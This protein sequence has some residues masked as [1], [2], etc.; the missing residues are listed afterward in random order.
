[1]SA[2]DCSITCC[3]VTCVAERL[4]HLSPVLGHDEAVRQHRVVG[5]AAAR[6]AAF[7]QRGMEPAAM[8]VG[9]FEIED[10]RPFQVRPLLQHEGMRGA[11]IEPDVEDVVDLL[12]FGRVVGIAEEALLARP[13][14]TRRRRPPRERP[15]TMRAFTASSFSTSPVSRLTKTAIGTPQA[16]WRDTTQSGRFSIM[17][18][19]RFCPAAGTK[20]VS[21]IAFSAR[22]RS[23]SPAPVDVAVHVDEPLR[24]VAEDHR[25][26]RAPGMR[27]L[28]LQPAARDQHAGLRQRLDHGRRWRRPSRPSSV[29]TC[30][31]S[32]PGASRG[33]RAV[34]IDR[35][36]DR[37]VD[38]ALLQLAAMLHPDVEVLAAVAGRGVD[39]AGAGLLGHVL[40]GQQRHVEADSRRARRCRS[41]CAATSV[42]NSL[43]GTSASRSNVSTRACFIT[44]AASASAST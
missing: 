39:E 7:Q 13:R 29:M 38:A 20:R 30:R 35:V 34:G 9:A 37:R 16:R 31:P 23:V 22:A 17:P 26:L 11:G 42:S 36:G 33:E 25:L 44:S 28:V 10:G 2:P 8:L 12:P 24:R 43:A 1:M 41:G 19:S 4:R 3:G 18:R 15:S 27:I 6:A 32:K 14:R 5:R 21:A 40:A